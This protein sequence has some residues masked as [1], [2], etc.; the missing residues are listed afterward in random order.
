MVRPPKGA[1]RRTPLRCNDCGHQFEVPVAHPFPLLTR[2]LEGCFSEVQQ[3]GV[4]GARFS[5]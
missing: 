3:R 5:P 1:I 4:L 2:V